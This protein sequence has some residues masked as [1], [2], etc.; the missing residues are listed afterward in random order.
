M[1]KK[2]YAAIGGFGVGLIMWILEMT[3]VSMPLWLLIGLGIIALG[4][5]CFGIIPV[6]VSAYHGIQRVKP[7]MPFVVVHPG[8]T[9]ASQEQLTQEMIVK[10]Y[11]PQVLG[12]LNGLIIGGEQLANY[13]RRSD[14][15]VGQL[16]QNVREWL[17]S[18][19]KDVWEVL[20][21]Y[22]GYITAEQGDITEDEKMRYSGWHW[23]AA[24]LRISVD[25]RLTRLRETRSR[26]QVPDKEGSQT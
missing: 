16:G 20:P 19:E 9:K 13:M 12:Q 7:R 21:D 1:G 14:F 18:V 6:A 5:I 8:V 3:G 10:E 4:M 25:R 26:I 22:A 24:S 2:P 15:H 17:D 11:S 23:D